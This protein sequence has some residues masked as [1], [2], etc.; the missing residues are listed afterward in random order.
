MVRDLGSACSTGV[1]YS[2]RGTGV[3]QR[4]VSFRMQSTS[5][6]LSLSVNLGSLSRPTIRS[7][8]SCAPLW[9]WGWR[10]I[11][12]T[13]WDNTTTDFPF[14]SG[15][16][17]ATDWRFAMLTV[18]SPAV[19]FRQR[20]HPGARI[21]YVPPYNEVAIHFTLSSNSACASGRS[22]SVSIVLQNEARFSGLS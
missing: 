3:P 19:P 12:R 16:Q 18:S 1:L 8:S 7:I 13:N 10:T 9:M 17:S 20:A 2:L 5:G 22:C 14:G 4:R 11:A 15:Q 21:E 6:R